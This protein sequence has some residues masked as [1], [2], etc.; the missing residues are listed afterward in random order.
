MKIEKVYFDMDGV[1]CN[2]EKRYTELFGAV[3]P[4]GEDAYTRRANK[5]TSNNWFEFIESHQFEILQPMPGA[6]D[7][8]AYVRKSNIPIEILTSSGSLRSSVKYHNL[9]ADQKA[10]WLKKHGIA[11][12]INVVR[13]RKMKAEY[14]ASNIILIDDTP[15]V[16]E[17]F[18]KAGGIGILH[19][20]SAETL[21]TL[22][23]L[24]Q[25]TK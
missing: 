23:G 2:F 24:F 4:L 10:V 18:D 16:I 14:A 9:V 20:K 19:K 8:L 1:L 25:I 15:D 13:N 11:Y 12:K 6:F 5:H 17:A 21:Q 7:M 22:D 3:D